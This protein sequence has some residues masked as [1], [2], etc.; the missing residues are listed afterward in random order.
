MSPDTDPDPA[1]DDLPRLRRTD[2]VSRYGG[3]VSLGGV[4]S[5]R[6]SRLF[7]H[8]GGGAQTGK[9]AVASSFVEEP[10]AQR[11]LP[12]NQAGTIENAKIGGMSID[13]S[14]TDVEPPRIESR[15][16]RRTRATVSRLA[17]INSR[18]C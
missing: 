16:R 1:G 5:D 3:R 15:A 7:R 14:A 18:D 2:D 9:L 12:Y 13:D 11:V 17:S 4:G 10:A 8:V 6:A